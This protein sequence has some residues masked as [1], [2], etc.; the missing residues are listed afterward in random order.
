MWSPL[1]TKYGPIPPDHIV[2]LTTRYSAFIGRHNACESCL[3]PLIVGERSN[4]ETWNDRVAGFV[5]ALAPGPYR[6]P[7]RPHGNL[8]VSR[9]FTRP[10]RSSPQ[11]YSAVTGASSAEIAEPDSARHPGD[12]MTVK[13]IGLLS[14]LVCALSLATTMAASPEPTGQDS[15]VVTGTLEDRKS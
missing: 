3:F 14:V 10:N 9:A 6:H 7:R 13:I 12:I 5:G 11:T 4:H 8:P 15:H 1:G 2:Q